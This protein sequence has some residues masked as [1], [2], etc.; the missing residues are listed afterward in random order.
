M[1]A[2]AGEERERLKGAKIKQRE[3]KFGRYMDLKK[4]KFIRR[5]HWEAPYN[6]SKISV[7]V[8]RIQ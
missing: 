7:R 5:L 6:S 8:A 1:V 3:R 4:Y 2:A